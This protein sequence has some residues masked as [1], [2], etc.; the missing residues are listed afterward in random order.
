MS[1]ARWLFLACATVAISAVLALVAALRAR[2]VQIWAGSYL[3][4]LLSSRPR[5]NGPVHVFLAVTDHFE[6]ASGGVP[7]ERQ[8]ERVTRWVTGL[9]ALARQFCD[10]SGRCFQYTFFFPQEEYIP[11]H[12]DRLAG[13]RRDGFGDVEVHL[14]HDRD[15]AEGLREKLL[16]FTATLSERHGLLRRDPVTGRLAYGFIHGNWALDNAAPDGRWCGV[17]NELTVLRETG[18]YADF[19]LPAA[20][21]HSQTR[22]INAIYYATDD[23]VA[24]KSHDSGVDVEVGRAPGGDLMIIQGPLTLNWRKRRF[25]IVPR[26]ENGELTA[27]NVP[28]PQR[29]DLWIR[30]HIHVKGRPEWVFV[31]LHAHGA[32]E[33]HSEILL[34]DSM[35]RTLRYLTTRYNDGVHY[36]LHFVTAREMY[37]AIKRAET[38]AQSLPGGPRVELSPAQPVS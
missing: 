35:K 4:G 27:D 6:P 13:L 36:R 33:Q 16:E 7:I 5:P 37:D 34:G 15:T 14:H 18:C 24:P 26:V 11:E 30:Q 28:T 2:N 3:R 8:R 22:K 12:L 19:T 10:S 25:G 31:K 9:P 20:P 29:A 23:P 17:N 21:D 1:V 32:P 38:G